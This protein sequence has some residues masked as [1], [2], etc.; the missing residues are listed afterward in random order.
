MPLTP[1]PEIRPIDHL[2]HC[3]KVSDPAL[4]LRDRTLTH[5]GL[6][7]R[8]S[9]LAAWLSQE[10]GEKG[11]R[12]AGWAAKG[13][14]TCILT[15]AAARAGLV[16]VPINPLLKRAQVAHILHDS[17]ARLLLGTK[18]RLD[19]LETADI[20]PACA[21]MDEAAV[22]AAVDEIPSGL[23][24]SDA[25]PDDLCA[26]L[27]TSGSTGRPKGVML[28]HANLWLGAVSVADYLG[29]AADDVT[30]AVLPLSF[31]YGQNQ[32]FSSWISGGCVV[33]LDY[34]FPRDVAKACAAHGVTTLA[35][36]PPL[37]VQ[38]T[39]LDWP[40]EASK[41]L[42]RLTNSGG[43]LTAGLVQDLR[44]IFPQAQL[45]PMYGL[46]EAFRSTYL[47]PALVDSH[48]TSM[49]TAIPFAEILVIADDGRIAE[50]GEE[51]EL[52][53][54]GPL[55][56]QGY[57]Q[58]EK[59][60][61]ERFRKAPEGSVYGGMA[62]W[63]GDRVTRASDGLLYFVGRRDAMIKSAGNR[64]SPQEV[65]DAARATGL[66]T[67]AVA[68]GVADDRVG[69]AVHLVVRPAGDVEAAGA[70]DALAKRLAKELPNF[71]QP[72][73][74]H[75]RDAMPLNPNGKIDRAAL[76]QEIGA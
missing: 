42:R 35:A 46:T 7:E 34:L 66:V 9:L 2:A 63:S 38:L 40:P 5:G 13:E 41:P 45:F 53:H 52:V 74:I 59:R 64:I 60:T 56:A 31:D 75:S 26:I 49:G 70:A 11:A 36:V 24:P 22:W 16:H 19:T 27:Y 18:A 3:G 71:M 76:A 25:A 8:V 51:G 4:V 12:V 10:V 47:D 14:L 30:L 20:P 57:W 15:L 69:Q 39:E 58:D 44:R 28:S 29:L 48:P 72:K 37:W 73:V 68:I 55:V 61:A 6:R 23:P 54:C 50:N 43:A 67:E 65:E 21:L 1:I 32:L 17:G 33:P 62:V